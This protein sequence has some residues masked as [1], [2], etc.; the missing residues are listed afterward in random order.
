MTDPIYIVDEVTYKVAN[1]L[2]DNPKVPYNKSQL[3]EAAGVSREAL[4]RRWETFQ[5]T[6]LIERAEVGSNSE[7]WTL[8]PDSQ[9]SENL[10]QI[11]LGVFEDQ[12]VTNDE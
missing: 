6:G 10:S 5:E 7:Y 1:V 9:I 8:N 11:M 2:L 4:Y 3:A 12:R